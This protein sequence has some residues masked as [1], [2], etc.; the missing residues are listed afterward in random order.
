MNCFVIGLIFAFIVLFI[1]AT[2]ITINSKQILEDDDFGTMGFL[3]LLSAFAAEVFLSAIG[4]VITIF[5]WPLLIPIG[6]GVMLGK[7]LK[8]K[9][10][11]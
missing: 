2:A 3:L 4:A 1:A 9:V 7:L 5:V 10:S 8:K 6:I 11:K